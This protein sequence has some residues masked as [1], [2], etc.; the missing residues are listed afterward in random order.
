ML[1]SFWPEGVKSPTTGKGGG[2]IDVPS[3]ID[4][5]KLI[6]LCKNGTP[7][8][9]RSFLAEKEKTTK[10]LNV[11]FAWQSGPCRASFNLP[12]VRAAN[13]GN[14]EVVK[15]LLECGADPDKQEELTEVTARQ[16]EA[17]YHPEI[18]A[19]FR[20]TPVRLPL[21]DTPPAISDETKE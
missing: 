21:A 19:V 18:L 6:E 15:F 7:D 17:L 16:M 12:I 5:H 3:Q 14:I 1:I 10:I 2:E 11:H 4:N 13:S 20:K 9:I 8:E